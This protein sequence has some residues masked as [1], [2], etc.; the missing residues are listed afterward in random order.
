MRRRRSI[1]E[2]IHYLV[3]IGILAGAVGG[4]AIGYVTNKAGSSSSTIAA[5]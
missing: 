2:K 1:F 5:H 4:L 3:V